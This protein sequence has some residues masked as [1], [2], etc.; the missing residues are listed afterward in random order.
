MFR[1]NWLAVLWSGIGIRSF[2]FSTDGENTMNHNR[3]IEDINAEIAKLTAAKRA[4]TGLASGNGIPSTL[5]LFLMLKERP[6][7]TIS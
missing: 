4:L 3:F 1:S 7:C 5:M 6:V 2:R